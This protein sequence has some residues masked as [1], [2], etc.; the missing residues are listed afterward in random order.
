MTALWHERLSAT[1]RD[2][3]LVPRQGARQ[4]GLSRRPGATTGRAAPHGG[5]GEY[6]MAS[7]FRVASSRVHLLQKGAVHHYG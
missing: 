5:S 7:E 4:T 1:G 3:P 6:R 2:R